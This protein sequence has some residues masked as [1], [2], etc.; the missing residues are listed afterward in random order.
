[1]YLAVLMAMAKAKSLRRQN[2]RRVHADDFAARIDQ[3][4]AGIARVQRRVGLDD[5]VHQPARTGPERP[6]QRADHAR[7]HGV[8]EAVRIADGDG[9]LAHPQL[10]GIA[11]PHRFEVRRINPDDRQV[12]VRVCADEMR[13]R[14]PAIGQRDFNLVRAVDHVAVGQDEPVRRD[15]ESRAAAASLVPRA[16]CPA[17]THI[18]LHHRRADRICR[19][20]DGIGIR[21]QQ[22]SI[23]GSFGGASVLASRFTRAL[24]KLKTCRLIFHR[25]HAKM[26]VCNSHNHTPAFTGRRH[27]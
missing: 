10:V 16:S 12:R 9:Q 1:M 20:D 18:N 21:V 6:A 8:L 22:R 25:P 26:F 5:V 2:H 19:V 14:V 24:S 4:P 17:F 7:R 13:V 11:E 15:D 23:G 3:R 27:H